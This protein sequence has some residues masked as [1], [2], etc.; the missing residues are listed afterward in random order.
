MAEFS[1]QKLK[2]NV[3]GKDKPGQPILPKKK[4]QILPDSDNHNHSEQNSK[5]TVRR[6]KTKEPPES[7]MYFRLKGGVFDFNRDGGIAITYIKSK[8]PQSA[9]AHIQKMIAWA[10][11]YG[12]SISASQED[13]PKLKSRAFPA[14]DLS[15]ETKSSIISTISKFM[16][17]L[18]E[19]VDATVKKKESEGKSVGN[20]DMLKNWCGAIK[21]I[22]RHAM[23]TF[24][25]KFAE[26]SAASTYEIMDVKD[27]I[28]EKVGQGLPDIIEGISSKQITDAMKTP[29]L[30]KFIAGDGKVKFLPSELKTL[31]AGL[32][33]SAFINQ[34]SKG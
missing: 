25:S 12:Y 20:A 23:N 2:Q 17:E 24:S 31:I 28:K 13:I 29:N 6:S 4:P 26:E 14:E 32:S 27:F 11:E 10:Q 3:L 16:D 30:M 9:W 34:I 22:L 7:L 5:E 8:S 21:A 19:V 1:F 18:M 33:S 15:E